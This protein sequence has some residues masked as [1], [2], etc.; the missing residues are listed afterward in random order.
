[1]NYSKKMYIA[2][3]LVEG[4]AQIGVFNPANEQQVGTVAAAGMADAERALQAASTAFS[5]W[6]QT[7][8]AERQAWMR[9]LRDEVIA[10][11]EYGL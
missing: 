8:I 6:S 3:E 4:R 2:G 9:K 7:S 10:H 11:D 1:M 5:H